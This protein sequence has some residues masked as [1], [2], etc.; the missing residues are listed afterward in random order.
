[1]SS[2][3]YMHKKHWHWGLR[4]KVVP[5]DCH[6]TG[7]LGLTDLNS[8]LFH[9]ITNPVTLSQWLPFSESVS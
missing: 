5:E 2:Q 4:D 7:F 1:M 6:R 9:S 3:K 8:N